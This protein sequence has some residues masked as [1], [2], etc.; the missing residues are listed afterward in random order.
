V[1]DD[2]KLRRVLVEILY[3]TWLFNTYS[4]SLLLPPVPEITIDDAM[5]SRYKEN[6]IHGRNHADTHASES[7]WRHQ[8]SAAFAKHAA[9]TS[10]PKAVREADAHSGLSDLAGFLNKS[11]IDGAGAGVAAGTHEPIAVGGHTERPA[12]REPDAAD[13][14][15]GAQNATG[16][17]HNGPHQGTESG[18]SDPRELRCGPLLNYRRMEGTMWFG[19]VLIVTR[20]GSQDKSFKPELIMRRAH[21]QKLANGEASNENN[22]LDLGISSLG[23]NGSDGGRYAHGQHDEF[24]TSVM[25]FNGGARVKRQQDV[26]VDPATKGN[27]EMKVAGVLLYADPRN[28]FWRFQ[29]QVEMEE[30]ETRW[31]YAIPGLTFQSGMEKTDQQ[32]FF[33][34]ARNQ[35]MRIMFHSC[36]GFSVGTDEEAW[37]GP[38]LWN[39]VLRVHGET[40]FHVMYAAVVQ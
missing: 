14:G 34:P 11:R 21:T 32:S 12:H 24:S 6:I 17:S 23:T 39:D 38:A 35:S 16:V 30:M 25:R 40:P 33:V 3:C 28:V 8:E 4:A 5:T 1:L 26:A 9:L 2:L 29:L 36:N 20:G 7:K 13:K 10:A 18:S 19:S 37:S 15:A 27:E 31:E 22:D